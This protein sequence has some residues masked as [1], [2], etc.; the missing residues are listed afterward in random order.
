M[1]F[2]ANIG[3]KWRSLKK[4]KEE[5]TSLI[6]CWNALPGWH[7]RNIRR[8]LVV[9]ALTSRAE[10]GLRRFRCCG[11]SVVIVVGVGCVG[12]AAHPHKRYLSDTLT[13]LCRAHVLST[14]VVCECV[15]V[16]DTQRRTIYGVKVL[17]KY[18]HGRTIC[19][20]CIVLRKMLYTRRCTTHMASALEFMRFA[21]KLAHTHV[22]C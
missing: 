15:C 1:L 5:R 22:R 4:R 17:A 16:Y 18:H 19:I 20:M 14:Y 8:K 12:L 6:Y 10:W 11:C 13:V 2:V 9:H 3:W 7:R 21:R